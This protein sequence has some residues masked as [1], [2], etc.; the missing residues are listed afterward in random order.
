VT[1]EGGL[2]R[3]FSGKKPALNDRGLS[4][5]YS[6]GAIA[7]DEVIAPLWEFKFTVVQCSPVNIAVPEQ[8]GLDFAESGVSSNCRFTGAAHNPFAQRER[9]SLLQGIEGMLE[10]P[11]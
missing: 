4:F 7:E 11:T 8:I 9:E 6:K 2:V 10:A 5:G 3:G 1:G